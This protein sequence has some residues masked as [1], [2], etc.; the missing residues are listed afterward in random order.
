[1]TAPVMTAHVI[2][3]GRDAGMFVTHG[4]DGH[5]WLLKRTTEETALRDGLAY[6]LATR[7]LDVAGRWVTK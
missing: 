6:F 5:A 4:P 7:D 2:A 3:T 1:M